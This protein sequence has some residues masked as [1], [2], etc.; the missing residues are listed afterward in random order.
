MLWKASPAW[1]TRFLDRPAAS[2]ACQPAPNFI[3]SLSIPEAGGLM[4]GEELR[5]DDDVR[6]LVD[7]RAAARPTALETL[8]VEVLRTM[9]ERAPRPAGPAM[10]S[11]TDRALDGPYGDLPI[12]VY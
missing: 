8:G 6:A 7:A 3:T 11:V 9:I 12:R 10:A 5:L 1:A 4:I 2:G